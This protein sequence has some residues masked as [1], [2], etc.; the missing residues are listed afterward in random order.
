[1]LLF[2]YGDIF[3]FFR[4][5]LI[6]GIIAGKISGFQI[7]QGFLVGSLIYIAIPCLM[8]FFVPGFEDRCKSLGQKYCTGFIVYSDDSPFLYRGRMGVL[9]FF[10]HSGKRSS[11][12]D[13]LVCIS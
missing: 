7:N 11:S 10:E 3:G 5:G 6:E 4:T 9:L 12:R 2:A 8:V 13:C 1:M